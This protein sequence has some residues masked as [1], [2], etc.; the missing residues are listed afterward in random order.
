LAGFQH[1]LW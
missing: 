1:D